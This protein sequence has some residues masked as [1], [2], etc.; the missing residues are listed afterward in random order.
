MQNPV[1]LLLLSLSLSDPPR[2]YAESTP[3]S[4]PS[5]FSSAKA[6]VQK[7]QLEFDA[8]I[9][10][11]I[12]QGSTRW[13]HNA[14]GVDPLLGNPSSE[15]NYKDLASNVVELRGQVTLAQKW[16][17]RANYGF[18]DITGG[19]LIDDD[20]VSQ[21]GAVCCTTLNRPHRFSRTFSDVNGSDL[22]YVNA[23]LGYKAWSFLQEKGSLRVFLGYQYW[24]EKVEATG[25]TQVEC[26][27]VGVNCNAVGTVTNRGQKV[28]TNTVKWSSLRL[29][30]ES[31]YQFTSRFSIDGSVVWIPY[32]SMKN[33]DI[34][35][36]RTDL[37]QNPSFSM[38][39]TG[40]GVNTEVTATLMIIQNL[41]FN[42]GY[43]YW[44]VGV[45]DGDWTN[46]PVSGASSTVQL[47]Q[48]QSFR[49]GVTLGL[50][51]KF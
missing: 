29:G 22:W 38:S 39:G 20:Y 50:D 40:M 7:H 46:H 17:L 4:A 26:T 36:L 2:V 37:Q 43:R 42:V 49:Q 9:G 33:E 8:G 13:S 32:T 47:N 11:W 6:F 35:H 30:L 28:I 41:F 34:H 23:D 25:V 1:L 15:L 27:S 10:T 24:R 19:R 12:S 18:G 44:W 14:S 3:P 48:L 21:A 5:I 51:Y 45:T 31:G 16:S